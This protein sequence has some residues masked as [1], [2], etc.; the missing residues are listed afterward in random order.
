MKIFQIVGNICFYDATS[1]HPTLLSTVGKY[2]PDV[3]FVEAPDYVFEGWGYNP[4]AEGDARFLQPKPPEGWI[5][6]PETG[7][8]YPED[9]PPVHKDPYAALYDDLASAIREGVNSIDQ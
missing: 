8:F 4:L 9:E 7:T 2:P 6:D 3:L 1:V 5:Y